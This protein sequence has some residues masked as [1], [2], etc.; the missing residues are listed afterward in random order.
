MQYLIDYLRREER[1][2]ERE[3]EYD[4]VAQKDSEFNISNLMCY[5]MT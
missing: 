3:S 4:K 1:E 5:S 2:R